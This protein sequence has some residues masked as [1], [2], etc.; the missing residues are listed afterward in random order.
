M[1]THDHASELEKAAGSARK[2]RIANVATAA[3]KFVSGIIARD[4]V[5]A[6]EAGHDVGDA[7]VHGDHEKEINASSDVEARKF[8]LRSAKKLGAF[9]LIGAGIEIA[10]ESGWDYSP[11]H[12]L[13]F[14]VATGSL[15]LN[16]VLKKDAHKH[17]HE[18]A[19]SLRSHTFWDMLVSG[20]TFT[21]ASLLLGD[22]NL[23]PVIP[24]AAHVGLSFVSSWEIYHHTTVAHQE[25]QPNEE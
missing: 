11:N 10:V 6:S 25:D 14:I 16:T 18:R 3:I 12:I 17:T 22:V 20:V 7:S 9:S 24:I 8:A 15:V 2:N 4:P 1:E 23:N 21:N 5:L 19:H 13:G